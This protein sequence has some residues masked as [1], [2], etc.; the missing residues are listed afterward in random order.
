MQTFPSQ[1]GNGIFT[2]LTCLCRIVF[3]ICF[4]YLKSALLLLHIDRSI[5]SFSIN[6]CLTLLDWTCCHRHVN[7]NDSQLFQIMPQIP[8][9]TFTQ[10][11]GCYSFV[12]C[13]LYESFVFNNWQNWKAESDTDGSVTYHCQK[14]SFTDTQTHHLNRL[15][16]WVTGWCRIP[17]R[18]WRAE[19]RIHRGV[20]TNTYPVI[21]IEI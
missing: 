4:S 20:L 7:L 5:H 18:L 6:L 8:S 2:N 10:G 3:L 14:Y 9:N 13:F 16:H 17:S 19:V 15:S 21:N 12:H 11:F 1:P